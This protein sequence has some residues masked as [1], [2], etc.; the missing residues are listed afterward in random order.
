MANSRLSMS[1]PPPRDALRPEAA[2]GD[3]LQLLRSIDAKLD[4][5]RI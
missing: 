1:K 4:R 3:V 5:R 2:E